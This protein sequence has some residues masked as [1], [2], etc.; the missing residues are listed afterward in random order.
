[1]RWACSGWHGLRYRE[2]N[3]TSLTMNS[4]NSSTPVLAQIIPF[5]PIPAFEQAP[6][7]DNEFPFAEIITFPF[8]DSFPLRA[9]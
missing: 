4:S 2:G 1:M 6:S 9:A 8:G 3:H 5:E 7:G